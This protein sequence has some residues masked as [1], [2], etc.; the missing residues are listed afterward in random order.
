MKFIIIMIFLT[1]CSVDMY[2]TY[3]K[4]NKTGKNIIIFEQR[5]NSI[6]E[7]KNN[8]EN[9]FINYTAKLSLLADNKVNEID[10]SSRKVDVKFVSYGYIPNNGDL[11]YIIFENEKTSFPFFTG[12]GSYTVTLYFDGDKIYIGSS[13]T[14]GDKNARELLVDVYPPLE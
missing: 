10:A 3:E 13:D 12:G 11:S 8:I 1:N 14:E 4:I 2:P 7:I 9:N 5:N 6:T